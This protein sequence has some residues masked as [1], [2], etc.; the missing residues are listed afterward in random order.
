MI[1]T[2]TDGDRLIGLVEAG[3]RVGL[4]RITIHRRIR[5]GQL[6]GYRTGTGRTSPLRVRVADVDALL[7]PIT[8]E[9]AV[10]QCPN[11]TDP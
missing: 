7:V 4:S 5:D 8:P 6:P 9:P 1:T 2:T 10:P 11:V 3:K